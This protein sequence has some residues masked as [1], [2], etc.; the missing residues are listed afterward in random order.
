MICQW[1]RQFSQIPYSFSEGGGVLTSPYTPS[2]R[3]SFF[4][5]LIKKESFIE[6]FVGKFKHNLQ[7]MHTL[8]RKATLDF[9]VILHG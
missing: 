6:N 9:I 8:L 3:M 2:S 5:K 1:V 4:K 7:T